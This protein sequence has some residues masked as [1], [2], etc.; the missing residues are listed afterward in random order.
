MFCVYWYLKAR[1]NVQ[2]KATKYIFHE[3]VADH[4][5]RPHDTKLIYFFL[6]RIHT[7]FHNYIKSVI[8]HTKAIARAR[9]RFLKHT[10]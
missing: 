1:F 3:Y 2:R 9:R 7:S 8:E 4:P 6:Y 5:T 10:I